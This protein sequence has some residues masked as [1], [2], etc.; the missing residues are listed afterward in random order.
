MMDFPQAQREAIEEV[1]RRFRERE[2][3]LAEFRKAAAKLAELSL[4]RE[5]GVIWGESQMQAL[6]DAAR[7]VLELES[8]L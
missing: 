8:K 4:M 3:R 1:T 7:R 6:R 5:H 2:Q